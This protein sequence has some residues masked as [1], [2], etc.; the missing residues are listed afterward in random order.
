MA[1]TVGRPPKRKLVFADLE[2]EAFR[3][4]PYS[5]ADLRKLAY[6]EKA[7]ARLPTEFEEHVRNCEHCREELAILRITDRVLNGQEDRHVQALLRAAQDPEEAHVIEK[8]AAR[9]IA[10]IR[11]SRLGWMAVAASATAICNGLLKRLEWAT[12]DENDRVIRT[13][14]KARRSHSIASRAGK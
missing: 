10:A 7:G 8:R 3:D 2:R 4:H 9:V 6:R 11:R 5:L 1:I 13:P 12:E 14:R